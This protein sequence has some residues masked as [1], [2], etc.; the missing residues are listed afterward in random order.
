MRDGR[1]VQR[2]SLETLIHAPADPFVTRFIYAQRQALAP[3]GE[4]LS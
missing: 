3:T 1:I 4:I 2:G